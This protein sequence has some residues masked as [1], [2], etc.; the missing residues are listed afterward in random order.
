MVRAGVLGI[1]LFFS[2][3]YV[4]RER[5]CRGWDQ[6]WRGI[7]KPAHLLVSDVNRNSHVA[8]ARANFHVPVRIGGRALDCEFCNPL[9]I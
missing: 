6:G 5:A 2:R 9:A 3:L 1:S 4:A 7:R 8:V